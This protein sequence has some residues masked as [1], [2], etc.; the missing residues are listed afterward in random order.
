[1]RRGLYLLALELP[2]VAPKKDAAIGEL[3]RDEA[4]SQ[5]ENGLVG[6]EPSELK[7]AQIDVAAQVSDKPAAVFTGGR[8]IDRVNPFLEKEGDHLCGEMDI[9][10]EDHLIELECVDP[11]HDRTALLDDDP[12][13]SLDELRTLVNHIEYGHASITR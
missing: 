10:E 11:L 3:S 4:F 7:P 6:I 9:P 8:E 12:V 13:P 5:V 2:I 1:V